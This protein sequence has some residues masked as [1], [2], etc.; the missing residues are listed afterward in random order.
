MSRHLVAANGNWADLQYD[1]REKQIADD[2]LHI[3]I[4]TW[5][6]LEFLLDDG[7]ISHREVDV[8][9]HS[10]R[11]FYEEAVAYSLSRLPLADA[12]IKNATFVDVERRMDASVSCVHYFVKRYTDLF[13]WASDKRQ[14]EQLVYEFTDF[15]T[16]PTQPS[17]LQLGKMP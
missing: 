2:N 8:F 7:T 17:L 1:D 12:V 10:A 13:P 15:Q 14:Q 6:K 16:M 9:L 5:E 4:D 3:G 11:C